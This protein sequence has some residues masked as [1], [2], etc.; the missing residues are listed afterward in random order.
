MAEGI[1]LSSQQR[2]LWRTGGELDAPL[3]SCAEVELV[4]ELEEDRLRRALERIV[5]R[6]EVLRTTFAQRPGLKVP[7]QVIGREPRFAFE[8]RDGGAVEAVRQ[9]H[10]SWPVDLSTGPLLRATLVTSGPGRHLLMLAAPALVADGRSLSNLAAELAACYAGASNG[11]GAGEEALQYADFSEW[12]WELL[13]EEDEE[14]DAARAY[15][16]RQDFGSLPPPRLAAGLETDG[17]PF[18]P[19]S[20]PVAVDRETVERLEAVAST[21]GAPTTAVVLTAWKVLLW[22]LGDTVDPVTSVVVDGRRYDELTDGLGP[23]ARCLPLRGRFASGLRFRDAARQVAS[24]LEEATERQ[25]HLDP[26]ALGLGDGATVSPFGFELDE[27]VGPVGGSVGPVSFRLRRREVWLERH[28]LALSWLRWN[29]GTVTAELRHDR[30][31]LDGGRAARIGAQLRR[32]LEEIAA[33]PDRPLG[34]LDLLSPAERH[35]LLVERNDSGAG[36]ATDRPFHQVVEQWVEAVPDRVAVVCGERGLSYG[37]LGR[38]AR[39]LAYH[40]R[41]LGVGTETPVAVLAERSVE[42]VVAILA[43]LEAG[44]V[45]VPVDPEHPAARVAATLADSGARALLMPRSEAPCPE[46]DGPVVRLDRWDGAAEEAGRVDPGSATPAPPPESLAYLIFTS[47]SAGRPKAVAVE[48]R[49]LTHY[50]QGVLAALDVGEGAHFGVVSTFAADLGHTVVFGALA[51]GGCLHVIPRDCLVDPTAFA[52]HMERRPVDVLKIVPSHLAALAAGGELERRLPHGR[53]VL[54]GEAVGA[55]L[56]ESLERGPGGPRVLNHYGPTET[57]V[58]A[59][60]HAL[61]AAP[62]RRPLPL[63]RPLAGCRTYVV[64]AGLLPQPRELPGELV[65]GG[66]GLARGY[67]G[68]PRATAERFV[69]DPFS[70]H[71]GVRLYRTGDRAKIATD[72]ETEFLGRVDDQVKVRGYRVEPGEVRAALEEHPDVRESAVVL[73]HDDGHLRLVAYAVARAGSEVTGSAL[74]DDLARRLPEPMVPAAVSVLDAL[75]LTANGKVDR[76]RLPSP[77][78]DRPEGRT[79]TSPRNPVE[80]TLCAIWAKVLGVDEVGIGDDFFELG[81]DSVLVIQV[82]AL[83]NREGI[84]LEPKELFDHHTIAALAPTVRVSSLAAVGR[85]DAIGPVPL[86]PIQHWFFDLEIEPRGHWNQSVLLDFVRPVEPRVLERAL[87]LLVETHDTLRLRLERASNGWRQ[88]V[89]PPGREPARSPLVRVDLR[90]TPAEHRKT[91][92]AEMVAAVQGSID[93]GRGPLLRAAHVRLGGTAGE[94][95]LLVV[96]H[97]AVDAVS[98]GILLGDLVAAVEAIE[99]GETPRLPAKTTSFKRW[100]ECLGARAASGAVDAGEAEHWRSVLAGPVAPLP[101]DLPPSAGPDDEASGRTVTVSLDEET[102]HRLLHQM[103]NAARCRVDEALVAAVA[104]AV[105]PWAGG[106]S[107]LLELEGHGREPEVVGAD[108]FDLS[109]TVGWFT[110]RFPVRVRLPETEGVEA[111]LRAAKEAL[112][113]TPGNG[114]GFGLSRYLGAAAG[115]GDGSDPSGARGPEIGLNYLGR[116]DAS[117]PGEGWLR[118][119]AEPSGPNRAPGG[120]RPL[121]LQVVGSVL[122]GSLHLDWSYSANRHYRRTVEALAEAAADALRCLVAMTDRGE[123]IAWSPADFPLAGLSA[124]ALDRVLAGRGGVEDLYPLSPLQEGL[125]FHSLYEPGSGL[126]IGQLDCVLEGELDVDAFERAWQILVERHAIFRTSFVWDGLDRPLQ[127]VERQVE[128]RL[129]RHDWRGL[130]PQERAGRLAEHL[131]ADRR[132]GY[133]LAHAPL[134]RLSLF[135]VGEAAYRFVWSHHHLLLDGWAVAVL[136]DEIFAVYRALRAGRRPGL[137]PVRPYREYIE[138]LERRDLDDARRFW[139]DQLHGFTRPTPLDGVRTGEVEPGRAGLEDLWFSLDAET[140]ATMSAW[141]RRRGLTASSLVQGVW[142]VLLSYYSG[143]DDVLFG[144]T[145]AGRPADLPGFDEMIGLFINT[146]PVRARV[147]PDAAFGP[148][149][150]ELQRVQVE[151]RRFEHSPLVEIQGQSEIPRGEPLFE[152]VLVVENYPMEGS[153]DLGLEIRDFRYAMK[154]NFPLIFTVLPGDELRIKIKYESGTFSRPAIDRMATLF[155]AA[156]RAVAPD[157][158]VRL[159]DVLAAVE[160]EDAEHRRRSGDKLR[161][162]RERAFRTTRR[163]RVNTQ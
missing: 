21:T 116:L 47:G 57:T 123:P 118:L 146:L 53:L 128:L 37:E 41:S 96:H 145:V 137:R 35:A 129:D 101:T 14:A 155:L 36:P 24:A 52:E 7:L 42:L 39:A 160:E 117:L 60:V 81:G 73:R 25:E 135:R 87:G 59:T 5:G 89:A 2:R 67:L 17:G 33:D 141:L 80:E 139:H 110:T 11:E 70:G 46:L 97:L 1:R 3:P 105:R 103:P 119:A 90:A 125:L 61:A 156:F 29:D 4:G 147:V 43:V 159:A 58:G 22:R 114:I 138:W 13:E 131:K 72:G 130:D 30:S 83:A 151:A 76:D 126:Y 104:M 88:A 50:V 16:A 162:A 133:D 75:P 64:D 62:G 49:Q 134:M 19:A 54:G 115:P 132:S 102:T 32:L 18:V 65:I 23:Y 71:A 28:G 148:W 68:R 100:A 150:D 20:T 78:C 55:A 93:L 86:T 111:A 27:A 144:S 152:S 124:A 106:D 79:S 56:I 127:Q 8:R 157:P 9:S 38:R 158:E 136:A 121:P 94:R 84:R 66:G 69:P 26:V 12:Q 40:L 34:S 98:W 108:G 82:T 44:G 95:L 163:K 107:L 99:R 140:T 85:D 6:H 74:R 143:D 122:G 92:L 15:W 153:H 51:A 109:R 142:S 113:G 149:L 45:Y 161:Q 77:W 154:E 63:G 10:R 91:A 120:Q 31:R 48:H 112:R